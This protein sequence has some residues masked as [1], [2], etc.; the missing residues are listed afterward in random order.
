MSLQTISA[1]IRGFICLNAHPVGCAENVKAQIDLVSA[2]APGRG[3]NDT[4]VVGGS[5]GYG[6]SSL[7][8]AV[9]GYGARG[10]AVCLERP[11]QGEKT[12]SAG[13]YNLAAAAGMA[14]AAGKSITTINGDAYSDDIKA[15]TV[16]LLK[17]AWRQ[18]GQRRL[19]PGQPQTR[20][21]AHRRQ[22]HV[23]AQAARRRLSQQDHQPQHRPGCLR[24]DRPRPPRPTSRPRAR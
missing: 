2:G 13:W 17:Q 5:T 14:R 19:Q 23:D 10:V 9:F 3:L 18:A 22:L 4:L 21:P 6:L 7:L 20:R 12:A 11:A 15:E 1:R 8:T 16:A 24:R